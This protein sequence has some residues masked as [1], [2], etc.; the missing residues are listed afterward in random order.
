M[1]ELPLPELFVRQ[2]VLD[3]VVVRLEGD[4]LRVAERLGEDVEL[5]AFG[6]EVVADVLPAFGVDEALHS[7]LM[8]QLK[9]RCVTWS[10]FSEKTRI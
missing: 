5:E 9:Q 1:D 8:L 10:E 4:V 6:S 2:E 7:K 3:V